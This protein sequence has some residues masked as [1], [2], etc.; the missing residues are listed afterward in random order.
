MPA[1]DPRAMTTA[2]QALTG[3]HLAILPRVKAVHWHHR[4]GL[5]IGGRQGLVVMQAQVVAEP[6]QRRLAP[7][8]HPRP[9]AVAGAC[10]G[11][12][13][14]QGQGHG[15]DGA[16]GDRQDTTWRYVCLRVGGRVSRECYATGRKTG[17]SNLHVGANMLQGP[18]CGPLTDAALATAPYRCGSPDLG[19]RAGHPQGVYQ[20]GQRGPVSA[21]APYTHM[22][23]AAGEWPVMARQAAAPIINIS[24]HQTHPTASL[25][26]NFHEP[27]E[28]VGS[29]MLRRRA[30]GTGPPPGAVTHMGDSTPRHMEQAQP[31]SQ[32]QVP[33]A[34]PALLL[35]GSGG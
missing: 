24:V 7:C 30:P 19:T 4:G 18:E 26:T 29:S 20:R 27:A 1:P 25:P 35:G 3:P 10:G 16:Q 33:G 12:H 23:Q 2:P 32:W 6:H 8:R 13:L 17:T 31:C 21:P 34:A 9:A 11:R 5:P 22:W 15:E 28:G 14:R